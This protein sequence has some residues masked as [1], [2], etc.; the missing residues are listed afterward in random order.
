MTE[1]VRRNLEQLV[2]RQRNDFRMPARGRV[3]GDD[4]LVEQPMKHLVTTYLA[5]LVLRG[6]PESKSSPNRVLHSC[7]PPVHTEVLAHFAPGAF[8]WRLGGVEDLSE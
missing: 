7:M 3:N 5:H 1:I 6:V 4:E 8:P 2:V